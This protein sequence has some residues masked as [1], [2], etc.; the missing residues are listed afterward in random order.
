MRNAVLE[1]REQLKEAMFLDY[2]KPGSEVDLAEMLVFLNELKYCIRNVKQW[3]RK[4]HVGTPW[5]LLGA[6]SYI[7]QEAKGHCL[8]ISPWNYPIHW[9][10]SH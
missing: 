9:Y 8:V 10:W 6:N 2:N 1:H 7:V 4:Q 5:F 3:T